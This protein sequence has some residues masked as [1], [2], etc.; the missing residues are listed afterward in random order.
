MLQI[1][2]QKASPDQIKEIAEDLNGYV[3]FVVD[4]KREI[5]SAGGEMHV[6]G[7]QLLIKNGSKQEDLWGGGLDLESAEIDFN[8]MI[9][10]R[11][12]QENSSRDVLNSEIRK[13]MT[14]IVEKI[15]K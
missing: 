15:L 12:L 4:I 14:K 2:T 11:P 10:L 7:E 6:D 1:L 8:S 13:K 3:K 9:N 5:I